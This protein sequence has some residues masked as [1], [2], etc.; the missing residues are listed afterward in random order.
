MRKVCLL[1][2]SLSALAGA[3]LSERL[4]VFSLGQTA[5][6][7]PSFEVA[8]VKLNR[9]PPVTTTGARVISLRQSLSHGTLTFEQLSLRNLLLQAFDIQR[10]QVAG[11]PS[12]C[13]SEF[14]DVVGKAESPDA[15]AEQVRLMLQSLLV[16]RFKMRVRREKQEQSGYALI[17]GRNGPKLKVARSDET[18][19]ATTSGYRRTFQRMPIAGLVNFLAG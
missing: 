1:L 6:L 16:D 14:F 9:N 12:W 2:L 17:V 3:A 15:T 8:S 13:D 5:L 4:S 11:C 10:N 18:I 19:G 7:A